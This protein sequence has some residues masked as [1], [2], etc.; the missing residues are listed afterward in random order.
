MNIIEV[1]LKEHSLAI[2]GKF[3][4][5]WQKSSTVRKLVEVF[6]KGPYRITQRAAWPLS[7]CV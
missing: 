5:M 1:I 6:F 3:V 4:L 7:Y 2:K